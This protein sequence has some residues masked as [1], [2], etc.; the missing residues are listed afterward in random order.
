MGK[1]RILQLRSR[2]ATLLI[3]DYFGRDVGENFVENTHMTESRDIPIRPATP[4]DA[5]AITPLINE[6][7]E[8]IPLH[9]WRDMADAG[10]DPWD[11]AERRW[12]ERL[13]D[14]AEVFVVDYGDGPVGCLVGYAIPSEPEPTPED[15]PAMFRPAQELENL[16]PG[17]WYINMLTTE[18]GHRG[19]GLGSALLDTAEQ[20]ARR[21]RCGAISLI[22]ADRKASA[23][24]LYQKAG[25]VEK[26]R[27]PLI[28]DGGWRSDSQSTEWV[29]MVRLLFSD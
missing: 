28:E 19:Q 26:A 10:E 25:F 29:L 27:R 8:G 16:C 7:G 17:N 14:G 11:F 12:S 21:A 9:L 22:V 3:K 5:R 1:M 13:A 15:M 2:T 24:R 6:A 4:A 20:V 23:R 18:A